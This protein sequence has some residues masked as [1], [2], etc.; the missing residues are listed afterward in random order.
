MGRKAIK[1]RRVTYTSR[2]EEGS[3]YGEK[4]KKQGLNRSYNSLHIICMEI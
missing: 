1:I 4:K 2:L 3:I